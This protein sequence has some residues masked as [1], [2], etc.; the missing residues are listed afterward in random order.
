METRIQ[1]GDKVRSFDFDDP[2]TR[3]T[4]GEHACYIEGVVEGVGLFPQDGLPDA[5]YVRYKIRVTRQVFGGVE[6]DDP[7][8]THVYP[9]VNGTPKL[10]KLFGDVTDGVVLIERAVKH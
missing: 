6:I 1:T 10:M 9:P 8:R 7:A 2:V 5:G 4:E 3:V